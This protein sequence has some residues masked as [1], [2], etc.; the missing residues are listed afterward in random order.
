MKLISK[1]FFRGLVVIFT[2]ATLNA[3]DT[4]EVK[5]VE[6][7]L[8]GIIYADLRT[9]SARKHLTLTAVTNFTGL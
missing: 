4:C 7:R 5:G 3:C 9:A 8:S 6:I 2:I 1:M